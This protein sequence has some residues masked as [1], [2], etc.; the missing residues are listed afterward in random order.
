MR[1]SD[2]RYEGGE[3]PDLYQFGA[4]TNI[5]TFHRSISQK[6]YDNPTVVPS[7]NSNL[8]AILGRE[9][10]RRRGA[11]VTWDELIKE[12]KSLAPDLTGLVQ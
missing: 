7:V 9:A 12:N 4:K 5:D 6:I 8:T 10:G 2:W 1:G 11:R 3:K